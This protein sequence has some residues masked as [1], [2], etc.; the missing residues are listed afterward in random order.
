MR[1]AKTVVSQ[2]RI[3]SFLTL[4]FHCRASNCFPLP[5]IL[6]LLPLSLIHR[7]CFSQL[8][9]QTVK[10]RL[11]LI[12]SPLYIVSEQVSDM[13][14]KRFVNMVGGTHVHALDGRGEVD[15]ERGEAG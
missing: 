5:V 6:R 3:T 11:V 4:S 14:A 15:H 10:V 9:T 13:L 12:G 2:L 8:L 1:Q 7:Q